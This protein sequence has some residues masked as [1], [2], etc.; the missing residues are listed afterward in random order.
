MKTASNRMGP[1]RGVQWLAGPSGGPNAA[2]IL[3][4][5]RRKGRGGVVRIVSDMVILTNS[6]VG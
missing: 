3:T 2:G 4:L 6:A 1:A 5:G